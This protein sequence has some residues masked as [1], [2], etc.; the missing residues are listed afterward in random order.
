MTPAMPAHTPD[1]W[2][3]SKLNE[4][5]EQLQGLTEALEGER[6]SLAKAAGRARRRSQYLRLARRLRGPKASLELWPI[7]LTIVSSLFVGGMLLVLVH[8]VTGSLLAGIIVFLI[9]VGAAAAG[10]ASLLYRPADEQLP[11]AIEAAEAERRIADERFKE[12]S[13]QLAAAN[14]ELATLLKERRELM[15]SGQVQRAALLQREWKAMPPAEWADYVVEVCRTL[16][17]TVER[18]P[19]GVEPDA[20]LV[21]D[22][23]TRRVAILTQSEGHTVNSTAVQHALAAKKRHGCDGCAVIINRRFTGAAQDFAAR[24]GCTVIGLEEFPDFVMGRIELGK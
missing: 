19:H 6:Q 7:G 17:A 14:G 23:R 20:D 10:L 16:G 15:A 18:V 1:E 8:A 13:D 24:N 2:R 21:A 5:V 9:S 4:R 11:A 22:F 3:L 12:S